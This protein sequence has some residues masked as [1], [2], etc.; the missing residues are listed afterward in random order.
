MSDMKT[1]VFTSKPRNKYRTLHIETDFGIVNI[2][3]GLTDHAGKNV[4]SI[5]VIPDNY[6]GEPKI[7]LDG[8]SH[9]RLIQE[10]DHASD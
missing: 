6:A 9:T 4:T 5:E 8:A 2:R 3:I 7:T 10:A 1:V